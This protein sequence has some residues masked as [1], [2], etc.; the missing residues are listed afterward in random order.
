MFEVVT[1]AMGALVDE[2]VVV[3]DAGKAVAAGVAPLRSHGFGGEGIAGEK[4]VKIKRSGLLQARY[5][6]QTRRGNEGVWR[7]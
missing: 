2:D 3:A 4:T 6:G 1:D 7:G 5:V